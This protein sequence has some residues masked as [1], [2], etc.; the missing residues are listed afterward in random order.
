VDRELNHD[1]DVAG[2]ELQFLS[3]LIVGGAVAGCA[4]TNVDRVT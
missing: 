1:P 2:L 3:V 4:H